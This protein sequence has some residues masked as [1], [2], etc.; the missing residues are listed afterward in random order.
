MPPKKGVD[1]RSAISK[2]IGSAPFSCI[3]AR[4]LDVFNVTDVK[5]VLQRRGRVIVECIS[6]FRTGPQRFGWFVFRRT[7]SERVFLTVVI[8]SIA[9]Q[10]SPKRARDLIKIS[11]CQ[12]YTARMT[13]L[14][15]FIRKRN[16]KFYFNPKVNPDV[17]TNRLSKLRDTVV[18]S[19][20][21]LQKSCTRET[22]SR[23]GRRS[24]R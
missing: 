8:R 21:A 3:D 11:A 14:L 5:N 22:R 1:S 12:L 2:I 24:V 6:T 10:F 4:K 16:G 7:V 9:T 15:P 18:A 20:V 23:K 17:D 13:D 19:Y